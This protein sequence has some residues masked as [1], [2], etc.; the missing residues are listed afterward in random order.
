VIPRALRVA[1][2]LFAVVALATCAHPAQ[3]SASVGSDACTAAGAANRVAG[4]ACTLLRA[5]GKVLS[6]GKNLLSGHVGSAVK[7][8]LGGGGSASTASTALGLAAMVA[9]VVAGAQSSISETTKVLGE[10]TRPQLATTWFSSAYWRIAGIATML[11]LPFLFAA[12]VQALLRSDLAVLTRATFGYLPLAMLAVGI[13]APVT[14]LLLAATDQLCTAVSSAAGA[15]GPRF[16]LAHA[17]IAV[18]TAP[19]L[20]FLVGIV[21]TAAAIVLWLELTVREAAVYVIVLM[22]PLAFAALVWPSRRVWAVRSVELLVALILSK[23]AIVAMLE[24]GGAALDQLGHHGLGGVM[25]GLSGTALLLLAALS[26]WAVLRLVPLS[27]LASGAVESLRTNAAGNYRHAALASG[28]GG[29]KLV[30][31]DGAL[32]ARM[33]AEAQEAGLASGRTRGAES[34]IRGLE[35]SSAR[36]GNRGPSGCEPDDVA[37]APSGEIEDRPHATASEAGSGSGPTRV[38]ERVPGLDPMFQAP[39]GAWRPLTLGPDGDWPR[40]RVWPPEDGAASSGDSGA[41][42]GADSGAV[43]E[44][45]GRTAGPDQPGE[46]HD[47]LPPP[48]EKPEGPL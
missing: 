5:P 1:A 13:A 20:R 41:A 24:L 39:N 15:A 14:M 4:G 22:M 17:V 8:I 37:Q 18:G 44:S 31:L 7:T 6:A 10:T 42:G 46:D 45:E 30:E 26:P 23:L 19:F 27:E 43:R 21:T 16:D 3:A 32:P 9:W 48:Q 28:G 40:P 12:A 11:T 2:P 34:A 38:E 36:N 35:R 29:R 33:R 47:P 25:A